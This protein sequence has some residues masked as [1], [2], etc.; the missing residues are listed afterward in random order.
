MDK[1]VECSTGMGMADCLVD[2]KNTSQN[3]MLF[4]SDFGSA[5]RPVRI[6]VM[7]LLS[8]SNL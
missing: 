5:A 3:S 7:Y 6:D 1:K 8:F 2:S 4:S